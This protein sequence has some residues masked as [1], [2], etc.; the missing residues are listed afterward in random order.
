MSNDKAFKVM[1][2]IV[3]AF[4]FASCVGIAYDLLTD[5]FF[6]QDPFHLILAL[7]EVCGAAASAL[8]IV[9]VIGTCIGRK[10]R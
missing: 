7:G 2:C 9:W 8:Y 10:T 1:S 5:S 4:I 6:W 3:A